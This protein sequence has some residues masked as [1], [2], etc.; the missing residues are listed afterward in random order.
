MVGGAAR[1]ESTERLRIAVHEL[2]EDA[3]PD[4]VAINEAVALAKRYASDDA[5]RLVNGIPRPHSARGGMR[6][7]RR[8]REGGVTEDDAL[9]RRRSCC[10]PPAGARGGGAAPATGDAEATIEVLRELSEIARAVEVE[11]ERA[12][13]EAGAES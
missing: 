13:R 8:R 5:G 4:E 10:T 2:D 12:R 1:D 6:R 3:V 9:A 11:L 7:S